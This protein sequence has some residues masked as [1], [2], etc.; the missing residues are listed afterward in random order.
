LQIYACVPIDVI[1]GQS[2]FT[3]LN[4]ACVANGPVWPHFP[5]VINE[6]AKHADV[7][8]I[9]KQVFVDQCLYEDLLELYEWM[10]QQPTSSALMSNIE[11]M[12]TIYKRISTEQ[13]NHPTTAMLDGKLAL[14]W[15]PDDHNVSKN[16]MWKSG[17]FWETSKVVVSQLKL[18][19]SNTMP[20]FPGY[21]IKCLEET[22]PKDIVKSVFKR[23]KLC[24]ICDHLDGRLTSCGRSPGKPVAEFDHLKCSCVDTCGLDLLTSARTGLFKKT[25]GPTEMFYVLNALSEINED[26]SSLTFNPKKSFWTIV[27]HFNRLLFHCLMSREYLWEL[28]A[29]DVQVLQTQWVHRLRWPTMTN[30]WVTGADLLQKKLKIV[31]VDNVK[32]YEKF[33]VSLLESLA[34]R[35]VVLELRGDYAKHEPSLLHVD[36]DKNWK[37]LFSLSE[38]EINRR[39]QPQYDSRAVSFVL[40][41]TVP[42]ARCLSSMVSDE[43]SYTLAAASHTTDSLLKQFLQQHLK[44]LLITLA[45]VKHEQPNVYDGLEGS[46][47]FRSFRAM[48]FIMVERLNNRWKLDL[49]PLFVTDN[50][51]NGTEEEDNSPWILIKDDPVRFAIVEEGYPTKYSLLLDVT[52]DKRTVREICGEVNTY[53][54]EKYLR[55]VPNEAMNTLRNI[56]RA[57]APLAELEEVIVELLG[58]LKCCFFEERLINFCSFMARL[59]QNWLLF[60]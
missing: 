25:L 29:N 50:N 40:W 21:P 52:N 60:T 57:V 35:G 8:K 20:I 9:A 49:R 46:G 13:G 43:K 59:G 47:D 22:Y 24:L 39:L 26:Y 41:D 23:K 34:C 14:C 12:S 16:E 17:K 48:S 19:N 54:L 28:S 31:I 42:N 38:N 58:L 32:A 15:F 3:T 51:D 2:L 45:F 55:K 1:D 6:L 10:L 36:F 11:M 4:V 7:L 30:T 5:V 18:F 33:D 56:I 27:E 37:D 53:I 44:L